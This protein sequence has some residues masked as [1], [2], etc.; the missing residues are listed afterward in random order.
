MSRD[1]GD[2]DASAEIDAAFD[3]LSDVHRRY[4][5]YYLQ[6]RDST[7]IDELAT[8]LA[9]WLGTRDDETAVVTP[10]DRER[11]RVSL[12]H[13]HLPHLANSGLVRYDSETEAVSL[14]PLSET[15]ETILDLSLEQRRERPDQSEDTSFDWR[16]DW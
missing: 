14:E 5:L 16:T 15:V 12:H 7:T 13:A 2:A 6:D 3:A 11:L 8:V 9:G 10:E 1:G 4:A